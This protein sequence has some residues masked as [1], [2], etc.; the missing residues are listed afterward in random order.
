[1]DELSS[2]ADN[3][4]FGEPDNFGNMPVGS[5]PVGMVFVG[6]QENASPASLGCLDVL[7]TADV[8]Q[9]CALLDA[10]VNLVLAVGCGHPCLRRLDSNMIPHNANIT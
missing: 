8:F 10:Q 2:D 4:T 9:F 3:L 5:T 7:L 6:Q 1:L